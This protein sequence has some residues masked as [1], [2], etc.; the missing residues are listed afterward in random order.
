MFMKNIDRH[1]VGEE[2]QE[3]TKY[4]PGKLGGYSLD[5]STFPDPYKSYENPFRRISLPR[6]DISGDPD[7]WKA[8]Q[9]RRSRR[10]YDT[11]R[12]LTL[13]LLATLLWAT[14][15]IT[16]RFGDS[17]FRTAPSAGGLNPVETYLCAHAVD[18]LGPGIYHYRPHL[19]DLEYIREGDLSRDVA[20]AAL[21][22]PFIAEAPVTFIWSAMIAR[23]RWKYRQRAYRYIYLDAGHIGQNLYLAA[24]ALG[25]GTCTIGAF[26]DD[27]MNALIG[28]DGREE[29]VI[30]MAP[31]GWPDD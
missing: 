10:S 25:L 30:Y 6:P 16:A 17:L 28:I 8:L 5:W 24:E 2:F 19:F 29:T 9:K 27:D 4:T 20:L 26:F 31:V 11:S 1:H 14:Q 22:Q 23:S 15:G 12:S 13:E 18:G 3:E 21:D 7:I